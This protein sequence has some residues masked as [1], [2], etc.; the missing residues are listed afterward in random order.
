MRHIVTT[1]LLALGLLAPS[2]AA[3]ADL[4]LDAGVTLTSRYVAN[5]IEQSKGAAIQP[6][7][8]AGYGGF[9]LGVW[10]SNTDRAVTGSKSEVDLSLGYRGE[11]GK[12]SYDI[13]Y[14][15][16]YYRAPNVNCCGEV[17]ASLGYAA[18]DQ[19]GLG[20][21]LAHDPKGGATNASLSMDYAVN[22]KF[23]LSATYGSINKGGHDYWNVGASYG[24]SENVSISGTYHDTSIS[25][26]LLVV[27]VDTSFSLR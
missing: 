11:T 27:S 14:A 13:G 22:D 2:I 18:T 16:Y 8:E 7:L 15:H 3:A 20:L 12:L 21:R 1:S 25:K 19:I 23:G 6:W 26:G 17:I 5:G 10:A 24:I 9:Y 4:T